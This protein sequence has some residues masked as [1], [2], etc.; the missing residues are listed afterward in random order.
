MVLEI[1][2]DPFTTRVALDSDRSVPCVGRFLRYILDKRLD[3]TIRGAAGNHHVVGHSGHIA[4]V[5]FHYVLRLDVVEYVDDQ[6]GQLLAIH[7]R[8]SSCIPVS[9]PPSI[10]TSA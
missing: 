5:E 9:S 4:D 7:A 10:Y 3:V 1:L 8:C 6:I 2:G